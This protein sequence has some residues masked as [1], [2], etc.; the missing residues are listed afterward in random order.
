MKPRIAIPQPSSDPAYVAKVL[1]QYRHAV[2]LAGGEA[3]E[4][5][6]E[7]DNQQIARLA[8]TCDA[9]LLPG[10][11]ADV[12]PEKYGAPRDPHTAADDPRRDNA[13]ELLLQDA[14]NM[15]KPVL[16]ICFGLQTLNVWRTGTLRQHLDT[17][18]Q[19]S[20]NAHGTAPP[21]R[22]IVDPRSRL[23]E[24]LGVVIPSGAERTEAESRN[25][26]H[27]RSATA[28]AG[29][30]DGGTGN[31]L[32][33][34]TVNSSHHQAA[35]TV[36]DGLRAVA[37]CPNDNVVEAIEGTAPDHFVVG[38]Q[39]HPETLLNTVPLHMGLYRAFVHKAR[40]NRR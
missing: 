38:V 3:V 26:H 19:H 2:E 10:C 21:H 25:L 12:N 22:A 27:S 8:M 40:E 29:N 18:V 30:G 9:V 16:G 31:E 6:L 15:R 17:G 35:E 7:L 14:Y 23:G 39:W 36:G 4:V 1:P 28:V 13:D 20:G 24:I 34:L 33:E 37:W 32:L 5:P 11:R